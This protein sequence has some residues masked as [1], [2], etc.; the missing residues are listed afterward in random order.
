[1]TTQKI[2]S[3]IREIIGTASLKI[4]GT[5]ADSP[6]G[7]E[8]TASQV[9]TVADVYAKS[10]VDTL[11]ASAGGGGGG[12]VV[13]STA[14]TDTSV[15]WIVSPAIAGVHDVR[16]YAQ[17]E[18]KRVGWY[19]VDG[20]F[21][22]KQPLN[23][24]IAG[25]SNAGGIFAGGDTATVKGIIGWGTGA[26]GGGYPEVGTGWSTVELGKSPLY[27]S[28]NNIGWQTAKSAVVNGDADIVRI[29]AAYLGGVGLD[30]WIPGSDDE[31][32]LTDYL[33]S[34]LNASSVPIIDWFCWH[35]GESG[36]VTNSASGGY[37]VDLQA[38]LAYLRTNA[39]QFVPSHTKFVG[40]GTAGAIVRTTKFNGGE[41]NG[42]LR[43]L[44]NNDD[45][46]SGYA[47][48]WGL[49]LGDAIHFSGVGMTEFGKRYR[50]EFARLP[51]PLQQE[52]FSF[53]LGVDTPGH[54][55]DH[56]IAFDGALV[57]LDFDA[58]RL[59][60]RSG[61]TI[62]LTIDGADSALTLGDPTSVFLAGKERL[63]IGDARIAMKQGT[64]NVIIGDGF[65]NTG[66]VQACT[67]LG[68][69]SNNITR[70]GC[71]SATF[72]GADA[73]NAPSLTFNN[74]VCVG[75]SSGR[76]ATGGGFGDFCTFVGVSA[77]QNAA[78]R[79][80]TF[81]GGQAGQD[82]GGNFCV[83]IGMQSG[84]VD[85]TAYQN[86]IAIGYQAKFDKAN[87]S[88]IGN[89]DIVEHLLNGTTTGV[90]RVKGNRL[91]IESSKTPTSATDTGT[92]G[93]Q[94]WDAD[95]MY[96]CTATN[97]WKRVAIAT[98]E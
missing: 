53:G 73:G 96:V 90:V 62:F 30:A 31:Q 97:T 32:Y 56:V 26:I 59:A 19:S 54:I 4:W 5:A 94:C 39:S 49:G 74:S 7:V 42:A 63:N 45:P 67:F 24:V 82:T 95:Y 76:N 72:I 60:M 68:A 69:R 61:G 23:I 46:Y 35:H 17:S 27:Q 70:V 66:T 8:L 55:T 10:E 34:E 86:S 43:R 84:G 12:W 18:W 98:W 57:G 3:R 79:Y 65:G 80:Q 83:C 51:K 29:V 14:P 52:P 91:R 9:R 75:A 47:A 93:D 11:I 41:P 15:F 64:R 20:V 48:P 37:Y 71:S 92:T 58:V 6:R 44:K 13:A 2:T 33:I 16:I 87:Q 36:G 22:T 28:N 50:A 81:I 1:M 88:V 40:G 77:G 78:G 85:T 89:A 38:F 25:Q 21:S